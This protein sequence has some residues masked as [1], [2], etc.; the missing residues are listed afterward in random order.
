MI[1]KGK[2]EG[3]YVNR[4]FLL[5]IIFFIVISLSISQY[6]KIDR[7]NK[8]I[9]LAKLEMNN[10]NYENAKNILKDLKGIVA[11]ELLNEVKVKEFMEKS[12][13]MIQK[14]DYTS[15]LE[16]IDKADSLAKEL[17][18][19]NVYTN[20]IVTM[21]LKILPLE[22]SNQI[23]KAQDNAKIDNYNGALENLDKALKINYDGSVEKTIL[24]LKEKYVFLIKKQKN[25]EQERIKKE[26]KSQGVSIGMTKQEVL[27]SSWGKPE[28]INT[29][30][31]KF[32]VNEQWVY[33]NYN[34]L[35][36]EDGILVTI[37]N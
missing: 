27:D 7:R 8:F 30:T 4:K 2:S 16:L 14:E 22:V 23:K 20:E 28:E 24:E 25:I 35:Y 13:E 15:A 21:R 37:Q 32:G 11:K 19:K 29:T 26:K 6:I 1:R 18:E 10:G 31:T 33:A 34:Y 5:I 12:Q 17:G 36:F 3:G 9:K